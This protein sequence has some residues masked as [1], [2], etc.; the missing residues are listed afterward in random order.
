MAEKKQILIYNPNNLANTISESLGSLFS[1]GLS[2]ASSWAKKGIKEQGKLLKDFWLPSSAPTTAQGISTK[3][4]ANKG[5]L[6][7]NRLSEL[8][9]NSVTSGIGERALDALV[10]AGGNPVDAMWNTGKTISRNLPVAS[11][12]L[13]RVPYRPGASLENLN[14]SPGIP[15]NTLSN[16]LP[17]NN[18]LLSK[19]GLPGISLADSTSNIEEAASEAKPSVGTEK[20]SAL[21]SIIESGK[22]I[23]HGLIEGILGIPETGEQGIGF[24]LGRLPGDIVRTRIGL[25]TAG[26]ASKQA[27]EE[28][29]ASERYAEEFRRYS[30]EHAEDL[31]VE[32]LEKL[33][34]DLGNID[35]AIKRTKEKF[36]TKNPISDEEAKKY[37]LMALVQEYGTKYINDIRN[38]LWPNRSEVLL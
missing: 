30:K 34:R 18:P 15:E 28:K 26:Q 14:L 3:S 24:Y 33:K 31:T 13:P 5:G 10:S 38:V 9:R 11:T 6:N 29:I 23:G 21:K 8:F 32:Q 25:E 16:E 20:G 37:I 12:S 36:G 1:G 35:L 4:K 7:K 17:G 27:R 2:S 22:T 19:M